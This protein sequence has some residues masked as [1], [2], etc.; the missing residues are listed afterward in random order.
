MIEEMLPP[1]LGKLTRVP[2]TGSW[3][4][5]TLCYSSTQRLTEWRLWIRPPTLKAVITMIQMR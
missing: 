2:S 1:Q 4:T 5:D 3:Y